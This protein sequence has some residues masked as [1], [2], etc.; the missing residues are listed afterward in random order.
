[1]TGR[2]RQTGY[3]SV[4]RRGEE[5]RPTFH[6]LKGRTGE[7]KRKSLRPLWSWEGKNPDRTFPWG[8]GE[9]KERLLSL[10][11]ADDGG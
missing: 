6:G 3:D 9:R 4:K 5:G 7:K 10:P 11:G 1:L 8:R 2:Q